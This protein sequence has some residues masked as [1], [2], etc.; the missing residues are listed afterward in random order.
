[1]ASKLVDKTFSEQLDHL[2][3]LCDARNVLIGFDIDYV[4]SNAGLLGAVRDG[5][6]IP[7]AR[8]LVLIV[9]SEQIEYIR[10][11]IRRKFESM[12]Y[13][14]KSYMHSAKRF[15]ITIQKDNL[16]VEITAYHY[17][18]ELKRR[19][20]RVGAKHKSVPAYYYDSPYHKVKL[21]DEF[22]NAPFLE[23]EYLKLLYGESWHTPIRSVVG[24]K[25][26][27]QDLYRLKDGGK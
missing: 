10:D 9:K 16:C 15:K 17:N 14:I 11:D 13:F 7:W 25:F 21:Y 12:G 4:L 5:E 19:E 26:R 24:K 20:R 22:F 8:G 18:D 27:N 6:L 1:M 2:K 3:M 23:C